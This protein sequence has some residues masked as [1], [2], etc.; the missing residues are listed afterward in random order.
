MRNGM[1]FLLLISAFGW[2]Q[3]GADDY[4]VHVHVITSQWVVVPTSI[5]PQ[6]AQR[7]GVVIDGKKYEL[8][9]EARGRIALLNLGDY[10]AKLIE[11][12]HKTTYEATETYEFQFSDK[13]T[14]KFVVVSQ[15]E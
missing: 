15:S 4:P 8:E 2:A 7:I 10:K 11:D 5:G 14:T 3:S 6:S 13:K 12:N 9:A 1:I